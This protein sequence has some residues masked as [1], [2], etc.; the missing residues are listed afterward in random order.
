VEKK[1]GAKI[2][3][4]IAAIVCVATVVATAVFLYP[5]NN[6]DD[7]EATF[8]G[9]GYEL[10]SRVVSERFNTSETSVKLSVSDPQKVDYTRGEDG[11]KVFYVGNASYLDI[12]KGSTEADAVRCVLNVSEIDNNH[13]LDLKVKFLTKDVSSWYYGVT[14]RMAP[15][16]VYLIPDVWL[17]SGTPEVQSHAF[18]YDVAA[19]G[20][21][22][23][24]VEVREGNI[25]V[26]IDGLESTLRTDYK[27]F[28]D[29]MFGN[30][31]LASNRERWASP[32]EVTLERL[33]IAKGG[34]IIYH[35]RLH[36]TVTAWG[37]DYTLALQI[38]ADQ[39]NPAQLDL[40][41][42]LADQY[43][44]RGEFEAWMDTAD[45]RSEYSVRTSEEYADVLCALQESGWDIGLHAVTSNPS[46]RA[47]IIP[48]LDEFEE[49]YGPLVSWVDHGNI[50]Q[51]IWRQGK[52]PSSPY[53]VS[54]LLVDG[55]VMIWVNDENH[56]HAAVQD[57]NLL[58]VRY[59]HDSYPGLDLMRTSRYGF[60]EETND[61]WSPSDPVTAEDLSGR[62]RVYAS[63]SA[64]L[65]WHGYTWQFMCVE[66][67]GVNH[68]LQSHKSMGYDYE[69]IDVGD[70]VRNGAN[71]HPD[72]TWYFKQVATEYFKAMN[73]YFDVWY[74]TPRQVYDRSIAMEQ[75]T[76]EE[77]DGTVT[78]R[79]N[80]PTALEG[81]TLYTKQRPDCCLENGGTRYCANQ[82]A[83]N[84][85]FVIQI[86]RASC[87]ERV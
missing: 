17:G 51:D 18:M 32:A 78:L 82:G 19:R 29:L 53:Y 76:V 69:P 13:F 61:W 86:G 11:L 59:H 79:N 38:H 9:F 65:I 27:V 42:Q 33:D 1:R 23:I 14:V 6:G 7:G 56:S 66:D 31:R 74:A 12:E 10:T 34:D 2:F 73:E 20:T 48:L 57:M 85:M 44:V 47:Q 50:Q 87:R 25:V 75:L 28:D 67:G 80:G 39:A 22:D 35:D 83:E 24:V 41:R 40:L 62:Q 30:V 3:L 26:G 16:K 15:N 55:N 54:D 49:R 68:S 70:F 84:W 5:V 77:N 58:P 71:V 60:L 36:K 64:V 37:H 72:G 63:N 81:V 52:D 45:T 21:L 46:T 4:M 43:G 8:E